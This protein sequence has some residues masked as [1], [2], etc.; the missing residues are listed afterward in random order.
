MRK[1]A[2]TKI[3]TQRAARCADVLAAVGGLTL[4]H[5]SP[6]SA[7]APNTAVGLQ[8]TGLIPLSPL[9]TSA[10]ASVSSLSVAPSTLLAP[11]VGVLES[12]CSYGPSTGAVS[13]D[14]D[15]PDGALV[16]LG[17]ETPI[18]PDPAPGTT[19]NLAGGLGT[20]TLT[21]RTVAADGTLTVDALSISLLGGPQNVI[22]GTSVCN[23]ATLA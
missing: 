9:A 19:L 11:N 7:A 21:Q 13:G 16:P 20:V 10:R 1:G 6:A 15:I 3:W 12:T 4:A 5:L 18:E 17:T 22:V 14:A 8:A 23:E 2:F